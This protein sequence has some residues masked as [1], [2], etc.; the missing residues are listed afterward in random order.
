MLSCSSL[1]SKAAGGGGSS[2]YSNHSV[3]WP[4]SQEAVVLLN[5]ASVRGNKIGSPV[6]SK[7]INKTLLFS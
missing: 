2:M 6:G 3:H 4:G 7:T 1:L 5:F